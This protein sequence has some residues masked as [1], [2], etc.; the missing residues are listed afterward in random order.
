MS[1][2]TDIDQLM[3]EERPDK[4]AAPRLDFDAAS[5]DRLR[6]ATDHIGRGSYIAS[7][8]RSAFRPWG[9]SDR[10]AG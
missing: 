10:R 5:L 4:Y 7:D 8:R 1:L 3:F 9:T 2:R 6:R